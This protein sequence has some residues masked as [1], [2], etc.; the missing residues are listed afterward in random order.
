[1]K[2]DQTLHHGQNPLRQNRLA[3]TP[4]RKSRI[5]RR[6]DIARVRPN[7]QDLGEDREATETGIEDEDGGDR[8]RHDGGI[9]GRPCQKIDT[10][11]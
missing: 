11:D 2:A 4:V 8:G 5:V 6:I 3:Q 7:L 10:H 1:M 9:I